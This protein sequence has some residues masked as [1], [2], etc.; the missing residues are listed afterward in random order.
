MNPEPDSSPV[1]SQP[2]LS[3][4]IVSHNSR[5]YLRRCLGSLL[6]VRGN[7]AFQVILVDNAS[8]DGT[9]Q[10]VK[11]SFP[12]VEVIS[13][14]K[15]LGFSKACNQAA[16]RATAP[17]I[18]FLNPDIEV[19]QDTIARMVEKMETAEDIGVLG[20]LVFDASG[21][22]QHSA[23]RQIPGIAGAFFYLTGLSK[24]FPQSD[25]VSQYSRSHESPF[26]ER[27]VGA[28]SGSLMMTRK[29]IFDSVSG[30]DEDFFLYGEDIDLCLR[31]ARE[32]FRVVYFPEAR[33]LHHHRTSTR[34]RPFKAT[35]HFY[36]S[37]G[38]FYRKH[39]RQGIGKLLSPLVDVGC[40]FLFLLQILFGEKMRL[41]GGVIRRE[42]WW[43]KFVFTMLDL[44][45]VIGSWFLSVYLRYGQLHPLPPYRDYRSYLLFIVIF[46][47][48]TYGSLLSL[49]AYRT[50]PR[51]VR[52]ALKSTFL[53]FV[54]LNLIFFYAKPIAF[55]RLVLIYFSG[56][57]FV[58]LLLTRF[59]YHL[60]TLSSLDRSLYFKRVA[61][62]GGGERARRLLNQLLPE[63]QEY[64]LIGMIGRGESQGGPQH[65]K[66]ILGTLSEIPDVVRN[67][68]IDELIV[69]E[70]DDW[71]SDWLLIS[72]YLKGCRV[73]LR[74]LTR[75]IGKRLDAGE[76]LR[77]DE[78]PSIP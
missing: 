32:G 47:V 70:E 13:N 15:N 31:I 56:F 52:T 11:K 51:E 57:L 4:I 68:S 6:K 18:L 73:R 74:F 77:I 50:R 19:E 26:R 69:V 78:L 63:D 58:S 14:R 21:L 35:Y 64:Q 67:F 23:R 12:Q 20:G 53:V 37:M 61:V 76:K 72:G 59:V 36:R 34:K 24:L 66:P 65:R 62:A 17:R 2:L 55:S 25:R 38:L 3:I 40:F 16:V 9:V 1:P 7:S 27:E 5:R 45:S 60:I 22:P 46:L 30:F 54:V 42:K 8:S 39:Y 43:M 10:M 29:D 49:R 44:I 48:V 33:A 71:E 28:V 75:E 41:S